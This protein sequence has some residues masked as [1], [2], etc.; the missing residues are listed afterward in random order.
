MSQKLDT[1]EP[2]S[3][4]LS[5]G[6][7]ALVASI[8]L[9]L[10]IYKYGFPQLMIRENKVSVEATV[11]TIELNPFEASRL[12]N[13]EPQWEVPNFSSSSLDGAAPPFAFPSSITP[14]LG[15]LP[16]LPPLPIPLPPN[17]QLPSL[18]PLPPI[19]TNI[20]LPPIGDFS[21]LPSPPPLEDL[22]SVTT[23]TTPQESPSP[24]AI[25]PPPEKPPEPTPETKKEPLPTP[26]QIAAVREQ[27][28][29]GEISNISASLT[30]QEIGTTDEDAR[31]NYIAWLTKVKTIEPE[32]VDIEGIYP[33]DACIRRL[34]G[35]SVYGVVIDSN[36]T[37]VALELIK[38]ANYPIFNQQASKDIQNRDF[39][40]NTGQPKPYRVNVNYKYNVEICPSLT[41]PSLR[42]KT[43]TPTPTPKVEP[44]PTEETEEKTPLPSLRERLQNTPLL[45]DDS[46][47]ERLRN[48]PAL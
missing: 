6:K 36:N 39:S 1:H 38:S 21:A 5:A 33:K 20:E 26:Q 3:K 8:I 15:D 29:Q 4:L 25:K 24:E 48:S 9:H 2:S 12:P 17:F 32:V 10:L 31:K 13:L 22:D 43:E 7:I 37:V 41:L 23:P 40:N 44:T 27:K 42:K 34:E 18:P 14:T 11:A 46:I 47:K 45:D 28:I 19:S 16:N 30:K 35:T